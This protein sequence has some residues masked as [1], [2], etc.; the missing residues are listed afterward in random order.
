M[1]MMSKCNGENNPIEKF[2]K[3]YV[4]SKIRLENTLRNI[5]AMINKIDS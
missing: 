2:L 5:E 1:K 3:K 4:F